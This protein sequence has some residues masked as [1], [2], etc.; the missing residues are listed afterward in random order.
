MGSGKSGSAGTTYNYY[1]TIACGACVGPVGEVVGFSL[2]D[3]AVWPQGKA[4]P[5]NGVSFNVSS[6]DMY[7]F[8]AQ[9]W[10]AQQNMTVPANPA[11]TDNTI[12]GN[13][14]AYWVE[15]TFVRGSEM[16]DDFTITTSDGTYYGVLRWYWGLL[17]QTTDFFLQAA[18]NDAGETH[19]SYAGVALGIPIDFLLGQEV[20]AAPNLK[21]ILRMKPVQTVVVGA[22]A[23][24]TDGQ[25]NLAAWCAMV[26]THSNSIG[27]D[28]A[29]LDAVSFNNVAT[30]L[31]NNQLLYGASP[32]IDTA[33]PLENVIDEIAQMIDGYVRFNPATRLI[34]M[35][36]YQHG[37]TPADGT[38]VTLTEDS[39]TER[40]QLKSASWQKTYTAAVVRF[41]DRQLNFE[42][43]SVRAP[44][45]RAWAVLK[46]NRDLS[47]DRPWITRASQA[48]LHGLETLRVIGHAQC[49][50]TLTVRREIGRNIRAGDYVLLD[51]DI[52]PNTQTIYQFFRVTKHTIPMTGPVKLSVLA[53]NALAMIP[54]SA[55]G[56]PVYA[57]NQVVPPIVN[58]RILE[59]PTVLG[60]QRGTVVPL[61]QRPNNI[62]SGCQFYFDTSPTGTFSSLGLFPSFAAK[63]TL[64]TAVAVT[65]GTLDVDVDI[66]QADADY[67]TQEYSANDAANDVMLAFVVSAVPVGSADAGQVAENGGYQVMEICSV[68][69][70]TLVSAGRYHLTVLRGRQNTLPSAF[71]TANS[72]VWLIPRALVSSFWHAQFDQIRANRLVG[73]TP[74]YAQFRFCPFTFVAQTQLSAA[75]SKQFRFPLKSISAPSLT[76]TAPATYNLTFANNT[77]W[78]LKIKLTGTW[79]D[80]DGNLVEVKVLLRKSTETSDRA[81]YDKTFAPTNSFALNYSVPIEAAGS[82]T[83]KLIARDATNL[84]TERD[85]SILCTGSGTACSVPIIYDPNGI[86]IS[87]AATFN[88]TSWSIAINNLPN[89]AL[90][91]KC[92]TPGAV[93][94]FQTNG[95]VN[96]NGAI[97]MGVGSSGTY[98]Y[99][100]GS[101]EPL[102]APFRAAG[103]TYLVQSFGATFWATAPGF[104]TSVKIFVNYAPPQA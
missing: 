47:L 102:N 68:S 93:I 72:E 39:L 50:G 18:N 33:D 59:V 89:G 73:A 82:Y 2:A 95:M 7:V 91:A 103:S 64:H 49:T 3:N 1:G 15:Y 22:A 21:A 74:A 100:Q 80:P 19:P 86:D 20:Q 75:T 51:V 6:G 56:A 13:N 77:I 88:G 26:L 30:I 31:Q 17:T 14:T 8:D 81:I 97:Q 46:S 41:C 79:S 66:T 70:Q 9:T 96:N 65:D 48:V 27:L 85:I 53:D 34:E 84:V 104:G 94:Y 12:P 76:L 28:P 36:I 101:V 99:L 55:L 10:V 11:A 35:G 54:A 4:W 24:I 58:F 25:L 23:G 62:I 16:N 71:A 52:E 57:N 43:N 42:N 78:P 32:L 90:I 69:T 40:P 87:S 61:C 29:Q 60:G 44:D 63:A 45:P 67:F 92:S 37:V 98:T 5:S 83:I 38:Y